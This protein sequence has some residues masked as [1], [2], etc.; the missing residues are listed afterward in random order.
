MNNKRK[1]YNRVCITFIDME[2]LWRMQGL[3]RALDQFM[4]IELIVKEMKRIF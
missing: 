4:L 2:L 1:L 3:E